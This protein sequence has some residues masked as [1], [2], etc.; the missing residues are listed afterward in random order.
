MKVLSVTVQTELI[1]FKM[2]FTS[3]IAAKNVSNVTTVAPTTAPAGILVYDPL[4]AIILRWTIGCIIVLVGKWVKIDELS[5]LAF[6]RHP[7]E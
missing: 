5:F 6:C 7:T 3:T 4:W 2:D 1:T